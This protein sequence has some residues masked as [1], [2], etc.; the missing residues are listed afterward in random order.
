MKSY[1][2]I[3]SVLFLASFICLFMYYSLIYPYVSI[4]IPPLLSA[5]LFFGIQ[6]FVVASVMLIVALILY[7]L[8]SSGYSDPTPPSKIL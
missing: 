4:N 1:M 5:L 2:F 6:F 8:I 7:L 3:I